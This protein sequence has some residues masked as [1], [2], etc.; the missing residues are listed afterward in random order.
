MC[1]DLYR[2]LI[3]SV[4]VH[5]LSFPACPHPHR[6]YCLAPCEGGN[7][8]VPRPWPTS[9][10]KACVPVRRRKP[11]LWGQSQH[12]TDTSGCAKCDVGGC[13]SFCKTSYCG[14]A[15]IKN[16]NAKVHNA[17]SEPRSYS[18]LAERFHN[19]AQHV[20]PSNT[21]IVKPDY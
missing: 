7:T 17:G 13:V 16:G 15:P 1:R 3:D 9:R 4:P 11:G 19:I 14:I 20:L 8:E 10:P 21:L 2:A 6:P 12:H 18:L 5:R